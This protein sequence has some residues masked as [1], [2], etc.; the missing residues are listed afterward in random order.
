[1]TPK[2]EA[3]KSIRETGNAPA[4]KRVTLTAL[5]RKGHIKG[6]GAGWEITKRGIAYLEGRM[7][8]NL[9]K[10]KGFPRKNPKREIKGHNAEILRLLVHAEK[11][12]HAHTSGELAKTAGIT[13]AQAVKAL[14]E[15]EAEGKAYRWRR[16]WRPTAGNPEPYGDRR[17]AE[18]AALKKAKDWYGDDAL[19]TPPKILHGFEFPS[20]F[21]DIGYI[22]AV[23][24]ESDKFDGKERLYRHEVTGK[25]RML[26]SVDGS[27]I[28][29]QAPFKVT[30]RGIEG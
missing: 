2:K 7:G 9:P 19:V 4:A 27:T 8:G 11:E 24:Y 12:G 16:H 15:L 3:L 23:E 6:K 13:R 25:K 26:I 14:E 1:M 10:G 28:V 22:A 18:R 20:A 30:K 5:E 21:V 17:A 29:I